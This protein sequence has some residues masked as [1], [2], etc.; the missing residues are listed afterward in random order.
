MATAGTELVTAG[1]ASA[2]VPPVGLALI[3]AGATLLAG[4]CLYREWG[5]LTGG[6][7]SA[8]C[9]RACAGPGPRATGRPAPCSTPAAPWSN[10]L[11]PF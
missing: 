8:S 5:R 9:E 3:V 6:E 1:A 2:E 11:N 4:A 10:A 7:P